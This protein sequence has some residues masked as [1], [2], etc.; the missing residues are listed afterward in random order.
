MASSRFV[1]A[2]TVSFQYPWGGRRR[3][4]PWIAVFHV[5]S[6]DVGLLTRDARTGRPAGTQ[7]VA[8]LALASSGG[9]ERVG[10]R[11]VAACLLRDKHSAGTVRQDVDGHTAR[12]AE[13]EPPDS[14]LLV[15]EGVGDLEALLHGLGVDS[16]D[17][18]HLDISPAP[19]GRRC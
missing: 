7:L 10:A 15:P 4:G 1:G 12:L 6:E 17:V 3:H 19:P 9:S 14:P 5:Q 16:I 11:V 13:H 2:A 18:S 8:T